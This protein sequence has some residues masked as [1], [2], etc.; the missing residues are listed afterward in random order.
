MEIRHPYLLEGPDGGFNPSKEFT[1]TLK[2]RRERAAR[3]KQHQTVRRKM[4]AM[5]TNS[6]A[7]RGYNILYDASTPGQ[8]PVSAMEGLFKSK[9]HKATPN[10]NSEERLFVRPE[11]PI[12][13]LRRDNLWNRDTG[14]KPY[15]I[16]N[17]SFHQKQPT[18]PQADLTRPRDRRL[19]HLV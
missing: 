8:A 9:S 11:K 16:I 13:P 4:L 17:S 14:G 15:N 7:R 12:N 6:M 19:R 3:K 10:H 2:K 1:N 18:G 5:H